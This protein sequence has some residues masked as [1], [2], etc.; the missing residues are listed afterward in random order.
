MFSKL[1]MSDVGKSNEFIAAPLWELGLL[2]SLGFTR[3]WI[4]LACALTA[5]VLPAPSSGP[6]VLLGK[7]HV[8]W[9]LGV[10]SLKRVLSL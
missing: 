7:V 3:A 2:S 1:G 5:L 6:L 10:C 8:L 4:G 9:E